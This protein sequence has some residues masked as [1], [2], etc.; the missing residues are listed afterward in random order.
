MTTGDLT[1]GVI[2]KLRRSLKTEAPFLADRLQTLKTALWTEALN[3]LGIISLNIEKRERL[4]VGEIS[5]SQ[6]SALANRYSRLEA[7]KNACKQINKMFGLDMDVEYKD[8]TNLMSN[9][10]SGNIYTREGEG[11][12]E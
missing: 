12:D 6:G 4:L 7:R 3:C 5:S 9:T 10:L 1:S 2:S 11:T 8:N